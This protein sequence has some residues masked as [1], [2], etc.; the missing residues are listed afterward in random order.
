MARRFGSA[1]A[2]KASLDA[3]LRK[4]AAE[5]RVPLSTLQLKFVIERLLACLFRAPD[6][7]WLLK[8]GFAMDLRFRP[9]ARATKDVDLSI[10]LAPD[11][12]PVDFSG[13]LRERIQEAADVDL[14]DYLTYRIGT[15]KQE[16]TNAPRGGARYPCE[17]L[18]V[19]K[20]YARF[21]IDVGCGDALV[22]E[23]ERILGDDLLAYAGIPPAGVLVVS[24]SQ[25]F[26]EK[27][28]AYSFP[29]SGRVNTRTKDLVDLVLLIER[30]LPD[31]AGIRSALR[32]TFEARAT[33]PL[34]ASLSP[35]PESWAVDFPA[36]AAEAGC[37]RTP[38]W[39]RS[40]SWA[41]SGTRARS[42]RLSTGDPSG[43]GPLIRTPSDRRRRPG[44][45]GQ[46]G[47]G[48]GSNLLPPSE[49]ARSQR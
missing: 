23:P 16:L 43:F 37:R 28:H 44:A 17:A 45:P 3:H 26:A 8:G 40:R 24:R 34:P 19:G 1:A 47:G 29:W 32:A 25:Q 36:M 46:S 48:V 20:T 31:V 11:A 12:R 21:H 38:T 30:G 7:P 15:P 14:S 9:R 5:R 2:F 22:G 4:L 41:H 13:V 42:V 35:P 10:A 18:L 6:P 33:H 39:K 49:R 27:I